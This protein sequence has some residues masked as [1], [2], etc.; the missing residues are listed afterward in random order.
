MNSMIGK[1]TGIALLM[2]AALLA[3]LFAMGV[4]A[5]AGV[6]AQATG[7]TATAELVDPADLTDVDTDTA[8]EVTTDDTLV[9]TFTGLTR[10]SAS[11]DND[12][13]ITMEAALG[14]ATTSTWGGG[15][16]YADTPGV[17]GHN[18]TA[19]PVS[20]SAGTSIEAGTAVLEIPTAG[21]TIDTNTMITALTI[22]RTGLLQ[23]VT[24]VPIAI[25]GAPDGPS[26]TLDSTSAIVNA[27]ATLNA[28]VVEVIVTGAN[29]DDA[30]AVA[31]SAVDD[32]ET[33][34]E[35][36]INGFE[37]G[38]DD[39]TTPVTEVGGATV[40]VEAA[41]ITDGEFT[42]SV[43]VPITSAMTVTIIATQ[44]GDTAQAEFTVE[45]PPLEYDATTS[46]VPGSSQRLELRAKMRVDERDAI[47]VKMEKFY[48]PSSID[49]EDVE[50]THGMVLLEIPLPYLGVGHYGN[51]VLHRPERRDRQYGR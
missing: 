10:I 38:D 35:V 36:D 26:I 31:I 14:T 49:E 7:P 40:A 15:N 4:F 6:G 30:T 17:G 22:G 18:G 34:G 51:P 43:F 3:A 39:P 37:D 2:A 24:N 44:G 41:D 8:T 9:I 27:D 5:P 23:T 1:S 47:T 50:I 19:Y 46:T 33:P 42:A 13:T 25:T 48:V 45:E 16:Q 29:F 21:N 28:S 11:G 32:A 20:F 12:V